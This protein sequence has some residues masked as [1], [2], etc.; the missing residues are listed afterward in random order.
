[1]TAIKNLSVLCWLLLFPFI[2]NAGD[3]PGTYAK[4]QWGAGVT[5][6]TSIDYVINVQADPGYRANVLWSD[7]FKFV[8]S[9]NH[10]YAGMEDNAHLGPNFVFSVTG[11]TQYQPGS[12]GSYCV[13]ND[14]GVTCRLPY[15]WINTEQYQFHVAYVGGQWLDVTVTQLY[16]NPL[17]TFDLGSILTDSTSISP[18]GMVA[19]TKYL[20]ANSPNANCYD[21][22]YSD[23]IFSE[24]TGDNGQYTAT[25]S[26]TGT[27]PAC[28]D[29]SS[30]LNGEQTN[31]W[32]NYLRGEVQSTTTGRCMDAGNGKTN[33]AAVTTQT[34]NKKAEGQAWVYAKDETLRL[35]SN[36]C[37]DI[38]NAD[39][40]AGAAVIADQCN[41][42]TS[43]LW[44]LNGD[45]HIF[46]SELSGYC[47]TEGNAGAQLTMQECTDDGDTQMWTLPEP[48]VLP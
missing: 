40:S 23:T 17:E 11:A 38:A 20:E 36:L 47:I 41:G 35:Q 8:G 25:T 15:A 3:V 28:A 24:P 32:G 9:S 1:M 19:R 6:L 14:R 45:G 48:P 27:N 13:V 30:V 37:L 44:E 26:T 29:F 39:P 7:R 18:Q 42:S 31:G 33:D 12:A 2:V 21:Q 22:P 16:S 10:G 34:C 5:G 4:Y 43:Q 46:V